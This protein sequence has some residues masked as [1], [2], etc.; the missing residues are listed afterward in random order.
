MPNTIKQRPL[1]PIMAELASK[2]FDPLG[3]LA[4]AI[5]DIITRADKTVNNNGEIQAQANVT[6]RTEPLSTTVGNLT[7]TGQLNNFTNVAAGRNTDNLSDGTGSPL[8]GGKRGF[9][10]LDTNNRLANSSRANAL[11][12]SNTPTSSTVLSNAG[13]AAT[14]ISI[15]AST[16][17]FG[18][19]TISYNSGSVDPGVQGSFF[20][21]ADDP[22]FAGGAVTYQFSASAPNQTAAD[23]RVNFGKITTS[24]VA[25][26]GGGSSGGTTPGGGGGRGFIQG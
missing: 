1:E 21:F 23:G 10:A 13:G 9:V 24:A 4:I 19:G 12:V 5:R 2:G 7:A 17:Q 6:G 14:S 25:S 15:A 8:T 11:N 3:P 22:T 18:N 20:V 26:T 16:A